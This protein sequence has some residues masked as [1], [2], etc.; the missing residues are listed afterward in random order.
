[1]QAVGFGWQAAWSA[2][3]FGWGLPGLCVTRC[4]GPSDQTKRAPGML[5]RA[6][7]LAGIPD[8]AGALE[9]NVRIMS[10]LASRRAS[11]KPAQGRCIQIPTMGVALQDRQVTDSQ[12][13]ASVLIEIAEIASETF[14]LQDVFHR[15]AAA[16]RRV[17][18]FDNMR[19]VRII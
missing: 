11:F 5:D 14:E 13:L 12:S 9:D 4:P 18:P 1:M 8:G 17:I 19:V 16:V 7:E 2:S 15:V 10:T 6:D 3:R